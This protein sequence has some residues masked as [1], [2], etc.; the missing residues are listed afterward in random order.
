VDGNQPAV[1]NSGRLTISFNVIEGAL[2]CKEN[3]PP[4]QGTANV[5]GDKEDQCARL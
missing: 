1:K 2:Q 3:N 5:A 4:P